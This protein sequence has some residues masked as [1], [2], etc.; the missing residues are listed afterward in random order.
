M[1]KQNRRSIL[2][3]VYML[4]GGPISWISRKQKSVATSTSEAEY[5]AISTCAKEALWITQLLIDIKFNGYL[6]G[7]P[8][9]V[10][11][12]EDERHQKNSPVLL[13]GDNQS[14]LTLAKDAH[15]QEKSKH[16]DVA[17][18]HIRD[19]HKKN[20][21]KVEYVP[22]QEMVADGLTKPLPKQNF[23]RFLSQLGL[24]SSGSS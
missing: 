13:R 16:I 9:R 21:I 2:G 7:N 12:R 3:Y 23:K 20:Q 11:I 5:M 8:Y 15:I 24:A 22:S 14:T 6:G 10:N 4:G 19:L 1:D 17:Y 18:H